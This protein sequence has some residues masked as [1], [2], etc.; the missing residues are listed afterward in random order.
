MKKLIFACLSLF[1]ISAYAQDDTAK[2]KPVVLPAGFTSQLNVVY[3]QPAGW[4]GKMDIYLPPNAGKSTPI[5]IN[6]HGGGWNHGTKESQTG[7]NWFFKRGYAVAN[8]EYRLESQAKAPAA[9][10]D[11]R[12]ALIYI[13]KHARELN[14]DLDKIVI[15]GTSAG[16]H[17]ALM[18][19]LLANNPLF[20][21]NC[22]GTALVKVA[23]I[24][25]EYGITDVPDWGTKS[26]SVAKWLGPHTGDIEFA[27]SVSPINYIHKGNPPVFIVHGNADKTVPYQQSV[28]LHDKLLAAGVKTEFITIEGGDHGKFNKDQKDM[29][30][31][32]LDKFLKELGL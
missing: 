32:A 28:R 6:I 29:I 12:C 15:M 16:A 17:L 21:T 5:V 8:M 4:D 9:V 2:V 27:N 18:G 24:V 25:D 1:A 13:I 7:F 20:D 11:T 19:G 3:T 14:I 30:N 22:P 26:S 31:V 10:Q 23:A